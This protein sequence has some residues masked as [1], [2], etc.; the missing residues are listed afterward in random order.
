MPD[1]PAPLDPFA[2]QH[3]NWAQWFGSDWQAVRAATAA[4]AQAAMEDWGLSDAQPF[5]G[6]GV[7][8]V[9]R[10][11]LRTREAVVLK[12]EPAA[13]SWT[14]QAA[15]RALVVWGRAGLAPRVI[16][17]RDDGRTL[18]L[19]LV[20]PGTQLSAHAGSPDESFAVVADMARRLRGAERNTT[21]GPFPTISEHAAADGWR[22]V[23][24]RSCPEAVAELDALLALPAA[25]LIHNDLYQDNILRA[26]SG[27]VVID[28]KPVLADPH[29]ECFA[30]LAAAEYVTGLGV[31][32]RYARSAD[33]PDPLLLARW[34]RIRA[35]VTTAQ[36]SE[37]ARPTSD[38]ARWDAHLRALARMLEPPIG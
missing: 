35:M 10:A 7:G 17:T 14:P 29:A 36:R 33:L 2:R 19:E 6:G 8:Y 15:D 28:P 37:S 27:W 21:D 18:L 20:T 30:L 25:T 26:R 23:L 1:E 38:S 22:R 32:E 34:V 31:V 5:G 16:A 12:V 13:P 9:Y 4:R 24:E 11:R 3:R